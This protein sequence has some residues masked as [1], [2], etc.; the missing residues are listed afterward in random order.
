M[1]NTNQYY[2]IIQDRVITTSNH[3]NTS[4]QT[5]INNQDSIRIPI[6]TTHNKDII[7]PIHSITPTKAIHNTTNTA[8]I[9][10]TAESV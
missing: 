10:R 7:T 9:H 5:P 8:A 6:L 1:I 4:I 2:N 3:I